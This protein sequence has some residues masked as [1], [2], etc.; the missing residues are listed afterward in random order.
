MDNQTIVQV[1]YKMLKTR[2]FEEKA[3]MLFEKG[4]VKAPLYLSVGQEAT[5]GAVCALNREDIIFASHRNFTA[6]IAADVDIAAIY[7]EMLG[8]SGGV[9]RGRSGAYGISDRSVNFYGSSPIPASQFPKAVGAALGMKLRSEQALVVCFAGDG[10]ASSGSFYEA[11]NMGCLYK[12]PIIFYIENNAYAG[13]MK[14]GKVNNVRSIASRAEGFDIVGIIVD[15]NNPIE[16][17]E[18]TKKAADYAKRTRAPI[19]IEA[20]SYRRLGHV[21]GEDESYREQ[22]EYRLAAR[23]DALATMSEYIIENKI[24]T[25]DDLKLIRKRVEEEVERSLTNAMALAKKETGVD[26]L[27]AL[28]DERNI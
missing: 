11:L 2:L 19:I 17:Y 26:L 5:A 9:C 4:I 16:V 12:L 18:A 28:A 25:E 21:Y 1:F 13:K 6:A 3:A 7:A 23:R 10:A 24:G 15:G 27:S 22:D 20:K 14:S 8:V